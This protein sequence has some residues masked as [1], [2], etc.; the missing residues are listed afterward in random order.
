MYFQADVNAVGE[1]LGSAVDVLNAVD[2]SVASLSPKAENMDMLLSQ[3]A[4]TAAQ[5][6]ALLEECGDLLSV[7]TSLEVE[8]RSLRTQ[9]IQL[10]SEK[11]RASA[12]WP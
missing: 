10:E 9:L 5:E 4:K 3:L 1:A 8:E 2:L 6:R 11:G 7:A 12:T